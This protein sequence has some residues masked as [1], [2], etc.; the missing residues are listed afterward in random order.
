MEKEPLTL[1]VT[2]LGAK[3]LREGRSFGKNSPFCRLTLGSKSY[4]THT[5]KDGGLQPLFNESFKFAVVA[6]DAG[7]S[8]AI[9]V[10]DE[11]SKTS[12]PLLGDGLLPLARVF[13][14]GRDDT[15]LRLEYK[16]KPAGELTILLA[17]EQHAVHATAR[18]AIAAPPAQELQQPLQQL[19]PQPQPQLQQLQ[20]TKVSVPLPVLPSPYVGYEY[21]SPNAG[22][23]PPSGAV[24]PNPLLPAVAQTFAPPAP[25]VNQVLR[26]PHYSAITTAVAGL[27]PHAPVVLVALLDTAASMQQPTSAS[28]PRPLS[29][30]AFESLMRF[31]ETVEECQV[32]MSVPAGVRTMAS[33]QAGAP[34]DLGYLCRATGPSLWARLEWCGGHVL[35]PAWSSLQAAFNRECGGGAILR[36]I[37]VTDCAPADLQAV[38]DL[39]LCSNAYVLVALFGSDQAISVAYTSWLS[40]AMASGSRINVVPFENVE[41]MEVANCLASHLL[42]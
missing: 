31:V 38:G 27:D 4:R 7:G 34:A 22:Y 12:T 14:S 20:D 42:G 21:Q 35:A 9:E 36:T 13:A 37:L 26:P 11:Y 10:L 24:M 18:A 19:Q 6:S 8:L 15:R 33:E 5:N 28:N 1:C 16:G 23:L 30:V 17:L 2:V 40:L 41:P 29:V 39:I 25:P 32:G 3:S